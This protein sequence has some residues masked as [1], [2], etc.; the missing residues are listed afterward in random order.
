MAQSFLSLILDERRVGYVFPHLGAGSRVPQ[1]HGRVVR[2]G[3]HVQLVRRELH[4]VR[5]ALVPLRP[6]EARS[7]T[8]PVT[9]Q[10]SRVKEQGRMIL[11][12]MLRKN[13]DRPR[14]VSNLRA[15]NCLRIV[16]DP[17]SKSCTTP[18]SHPAA[19]ARPSERK[20][21]PYACGRAG[22]EAKGFFRIPAAGRR[23]GGGPGWVSASA[24]SGAGREEAARRF[25]EPGDCLLQRFCGAVIDEHLRAISGGD[26]A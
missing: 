20:T 3:K 15:L 17:T 23:G 8:F 5:R 6:S 24:R 4:R 13:A 9:S 22:Q 2:P 26:E 1:S 25:L 12:P 18:D 19:T 11:P 16:L 10:S 14:G 7:W 21:P